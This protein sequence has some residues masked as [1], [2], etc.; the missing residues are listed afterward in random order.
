[1]S[2]L[3]SSSR[4]LTGCWRK[5]AACFASAAIKPAP[6]WAGAMPSV[7]GPRAARV[8]VVHHRT[9]M[10][11]AIVT[12][13]DA[14][15]Q[16]RWSLWKTWQPLTRCHW[17]SCRNSCPNRP[18]DIPGQ[19]VAA[20]AIMVSLGVLGPSGSWTTGW[21]RQVTPG[22]HNETVNS[23]WKLLAHTM[24]RTLRLITVENIRGFWKGLPV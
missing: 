4:S 11:L 15:C 24:W 19:S 14:D 8:A 12:L 3:L 18:M 23:L 13:R 20:H 5:W 16:E 6:S 10:D 17:P 1:M 2:S 22:R 9:Q 21:Q 7:R